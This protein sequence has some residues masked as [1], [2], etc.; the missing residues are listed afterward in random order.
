MR[1]NKLII[2]FFA[3][4]L[5]A[6][7]AQQLS[8][9][10]GK[11]D[12]VAP[13]LIKAIPENESVNFTA[14]EINLRFDEFITLK[15]LNQQLLVSP[16][17]KNQAEITA[18]G[19]NIKIKLKD[20]LLSNTTYQIYL[21]SAI[22]DIHENNKTENFTY[23]FSTGKEIDTL[24][25]SGKVLNAYTLLPAEGINV[26]VYPINADSIALKGMPRYIAKTN[27]TG[28]YTV[29]GL[30]AGHYKI[31]ALKDA[32][33]DYI[34]QSSNEQIGFLNTPIKIEA[35]TSKKETNADP[36]YIFEETPDK[37]YIKKINNQLYGKV[38]IVFNRWLINPTFNI[39][40]PKNKTNAY[41]NFNTIGDT[42]TVWYN[43]EFNDSLALIVKAEGYTDTAAISLK[44]NKTEARNPKGKSTLL[45]TVTGVKEGAMLPQSKIQFASFYPIT[46]YNQT[47][48]VIAT[49]KDTVKKQVKLMPNGQ[50]E[51]NDFTMPV[52][53]EITIIV[54]PKTFKDIIGAL[55]DSIKINIKPVDIQKTGSLKLTPNKEIKD[56]LL[57]EV[58]NTK[59]QIVA[60]GTL[61]PSETLTIPNLAA[62]T[63]TIKVIEDKNKNNRWDSGK[64]TKKLQ[65]ERIYMLPNIQVKKRFETEVTIQN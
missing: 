9:S 21:G 14:K 60:K 56:N 48:I 2:T 30:A 39:T 35:D 43:Q 25:L 42:L 37:F 59:G 49:A 36:I 6:S 24:T 7:C 33:N 64:Y 61:L 19:K 18:S 62:E 22:S 40:S 12:R 31:I 28:V 15:D 4:L 3:A 57:I 8:P 51:I 47:P 20:T 34:F 58:I 11:E 26:Q 55:N 5:F 65:P 50:A 29:H 16:P 17:F 13:K 52:S 27:K 32:N 38:E 1:N 63:H 46:E 41:A 53:Q 45:L 54:L 10:G 23:L 44:K